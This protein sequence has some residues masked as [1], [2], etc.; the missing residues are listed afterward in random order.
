MEDSIRIIDSFRGEYNYL[1]NFYSC[2]IKVDV[3][4]VVRVYQN[5]EAIFQAYK[6]PT[7]AIEFVD[8]NASQ[9]KRL[10]RQVSLRSDWERVKL[11]V[12]RN[13]CQAKFYQNTD[14]LEKLLF[15]DAV[16]IE[17]NTWNDRFW[18]V[19]KGVGQNWL[20]RIL[21]DIRDKERSNRGLSAFHREVF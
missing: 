6:C 21:M 12:M 4:G 3:D 9:A 13:T 20:G 19:C 16:L 5:S 8:L 15:L 10:G 2:P 7:R 11:Q 14:L 1:S 18:G 17:G